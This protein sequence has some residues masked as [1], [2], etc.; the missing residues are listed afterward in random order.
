MPELNAS[1]NRGVRNVYSVTARKL[2]L[3]NLFSIASI[4]GDRLSMSVIGV[5]NTTQTISK[6]IVRTQDFTFAKNS[7]RLMFSHII[8][9]L[10]GAF[11][12]FQL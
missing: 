4:N 9:V 5:R 8:S 7:S 10:A 6:I 11:L 2:D 3:P 1:T 12:T